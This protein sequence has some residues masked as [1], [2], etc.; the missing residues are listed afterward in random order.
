MVYLTIS[1]TLLYH[2]LIHSHF[3]CIIWVKNKKYFRLVLKSFRITKIFFIFGNPRTLL[4]NKFRL[5]NDF[6]YFFEMDIQLI[7]F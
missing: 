1:G 7:F 5:F 6:E 3:Y 4:T 2:L